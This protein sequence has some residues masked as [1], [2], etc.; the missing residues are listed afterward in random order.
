MLTEKQ[1]KAG[2]NFYME[3]R[4]RTVEDWK[5]VK[6]TN[7]SPYELFHPQNIRNDRV[8]NYTRENTPSRHVIK[9]SPEG[10]TFGEWCHTR[11]AIFGL[12]FCL[13]IAWLIASI[14]YV[15]P[16]CLSKVQKH[17]LRSSNSPQNLRNMSMAIVHQDQAQQLTY[18]LPTKRTEFS[19]FTF[20]GRDVCLSNSSYLSPIKNLW[21]ILQRRLD[22]MNQ[23]ATNLTVMQKQ[24]S[25]AFQNIEQK[26]Q[27]KFDL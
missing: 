15:T 6:F 14:M 13:K 17:N 5:R 24:L 2:F 26:V 22:E 12:Q 1:R 7:E 10:I 21:S 4:E 16:F 3:R 27:E 18:K 19:S 8:W 11:T 20:W 23:P 25:Y 9:Y